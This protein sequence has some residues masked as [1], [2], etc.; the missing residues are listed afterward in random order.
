MSGDETVDAVA[1]IDLRLGAREEL[2]A[3]VE[4]PAKE[5]DA[6][7]KKLQAAFAF[8]ATTLVILTAVGVWFRGEGMALTWPWNV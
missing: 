2:V 5:M 3:R 1:R 8:L 4:A 6:A 7:L